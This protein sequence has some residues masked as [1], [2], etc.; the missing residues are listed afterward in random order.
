M[1]KLNTDNKM[2]HEA[3]MILCEAL[4]RNTTLTEL[5]VMSMT[6]TKEGIVCIKIKCIHQLSVTGI[7]DEE[8]MVLSEV[9]KMNSTLET[10]D[11][12]SG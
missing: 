10:L 6:M 1:M 2:E 7:G 12:S 8:V 3:F 11:L 4:S 9:L 5:N